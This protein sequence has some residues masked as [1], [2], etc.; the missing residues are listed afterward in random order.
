MLTTK[1]ELHRLQQPQS[2]VH[3]TGCHMSTTTLLHP[4][5]KK[6]KESVV[7]MSIDDYLISR[8]SISYKFFHDIHYILSE[9]PF[10]PIF[11]EILFGVNQFYLASFHSEI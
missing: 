8:W 7:G 6:K 2:A 4:S 1:I 11:F 5:W 10:S 9:F 3:K